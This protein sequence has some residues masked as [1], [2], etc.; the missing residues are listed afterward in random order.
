[1]S[2]IFVLNQLKIID[3]SSL[4]ANSLMAPSFGKEACLER[5]KG[6]WIMGEEKGDL[7]HLIRQRGGGEVK[8]EKDR[9]N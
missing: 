2:K 7:L 9:I 6:R 4:G 8:G 1:M 5:M 3:K